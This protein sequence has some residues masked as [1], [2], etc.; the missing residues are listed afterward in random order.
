MSEFNNQ[1]MTEI[2]D[3]VI[4][5]LQVCLKNKELWKTDKIAMIRMIELDNVVFYEKYPRICR[6]LVYAEDITPLLSMIKT[7]GMVQSGKLDF[8]KAN[9]AISTALN[10]QYIDGVLNSEPLVKEREIKMKQ[11]K[12][13]T[14]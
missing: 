14:K 9:D 4:R 2:S 1:K 10:T 5:A 7:F 6:M 13:L 12:E 11:E 3:S 8:N